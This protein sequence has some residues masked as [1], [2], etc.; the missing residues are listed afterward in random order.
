MHG[1]GGVGFNKSKTEDEPK[2]FF[3]PHPSFPNH[4]LTDIQTIGCPSLLF[5][6]ASMARKQSCNKGKWPTNP[7]HINWFPPE[8]D[9]LPANTTVKA[10]VSLIR[11]ST[12]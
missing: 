10:Q 12:D 2:P 4:L 8:S 6:I 3:H 11:Q 1:D 9:P 7:L 5:V